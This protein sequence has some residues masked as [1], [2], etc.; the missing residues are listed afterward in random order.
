M[1]AKNQGDGYLAPECLYTLE[2]F[3]HASGIS[4]TR[5]HEARQRGITANWIKVGR[6][7]YI[8]GVDAIAFILRLAE[9]GTDGECVPS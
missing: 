1:S 2:G 6:R 4:N 3:R 7:K 5:I 8:K 9:V